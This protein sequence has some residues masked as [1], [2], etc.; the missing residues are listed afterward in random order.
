MLLKAV[1]DVAKKI[2]M[3]EYKSGEYGGTKITT[4]PASV[5]RSS[6]GWVW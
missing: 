4:I 6:T 3:N 2:S 5:N 1:F